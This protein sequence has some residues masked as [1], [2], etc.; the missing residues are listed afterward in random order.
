MAL[1]EVQN[2]NK[3]YGGVKALD[4]ISFSVDTAEVVGLQG[5]NGA[6]KS[7][8]VK[9]ISGALNPDSGQILLNGRQLK[10]GKPSYIRKLG[11]EMIY[12]DLSLCKQHTAVQN[13]LLGNEIKKFGVCL[14]NKMMLEKASSLL[15]TLNVELDLH[16]EV[17]FMSGGQQQSI[18]IARALFSNPKLIIMDEPTAALGEKET[19]GVLKLITALKEKGVSVILIS[20][21]KSDI[22]AVT[23]RQITL[24]QGKIIHK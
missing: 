1:L 4:S 5:D 15:L 2:I 14:D 19:Q 8:L 22:E 18:A 24:D 9:I 21:N 10:L 12:Q 17:Q 7:T 20:H 3:T 6:G 16:R 23:D 11:I 13:I